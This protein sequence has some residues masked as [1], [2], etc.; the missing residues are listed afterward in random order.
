MPQEEQLRRRLLAMSFD[1]FV[2]KLEPMLEAIVEPPKRHQ[3]S[4]KAKDAFLRHFR[5]RPSAIDQKACFDLMQ[6][7]RQSLA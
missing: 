1:A 5:G 7:E 3:M 6:F 4:L 2:K